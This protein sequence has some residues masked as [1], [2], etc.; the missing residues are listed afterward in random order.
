MREK[1][2]EANGGEKARCAFSRFQ[3]KSCKCQEVLQLDHMESR[4]SN[5][6]YADPLNHQILCSAHNRWKHYHQREAQRFERILY[7]DEK[8]DELYRRSKLSKPMSKKEWLEVEQ[9]L[10]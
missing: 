3:S 5:E 4:S 1:L 9:S 8:M 2:I 6:L 7:G 10:G